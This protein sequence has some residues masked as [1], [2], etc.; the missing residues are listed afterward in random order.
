MVQLVQ[1]PSFLHTCTRALLSFLCALQLPCSKCTHTH[2]H[3]HT[4]QNAGHDRFSRHPAHS[5]RHLAGHTCKQRASAACL[6]A[7]MGPQWGVCVYVCVYPHTSLHA[8]NVC[9]QR[10]SLQAWGHNGVRVC[11]SVCV[12]VSMCMYVCQ[13]ASLQ[14]QGFSV[15]YC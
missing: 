10:A 7:S 12:C 8:S 14:A 4:L 11:V 3:T 15:V 6:P 1:A 9:W 13:H 5:P 2:T